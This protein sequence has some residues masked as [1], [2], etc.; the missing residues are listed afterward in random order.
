MKPYNFKW[1]KFYESNSEFLYVGLQLNLTENELIICSTVVDS[2]NFSILTTQKLITSENGI[3][4]VGNLIGATDKGYG[5]F[6]GYKNDTLTFGIVQLENGANFK[7]LIETGKASMV[8]INGV[9]TS[10][11]TMQMTNE[12]IKNITRNWNKQNEK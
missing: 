4:N 11:R 1:T 8:M 3:K 12:N 7:Y 5:D 9:R 2:E 6:K 10:I